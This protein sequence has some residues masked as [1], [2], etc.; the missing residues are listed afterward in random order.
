MDLI[1]DANVLFAALIKDSL[2]SDLLFRRDLHLFIPEHIFIELEKHKEE[3]LKKTERTPEKFEA[4]LEIFTRRVTLIPLEE[5]IPFVK[6]AELLC[7]D[8]DDLAY[9]ASALKINCAIWSNDKA[10]KEKQNKIKVYHTHD[11]LGLK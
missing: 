1:V 8:P 9:F 5:L 7:P 3:I 11:L 10:L 6:E 2:S 4:L